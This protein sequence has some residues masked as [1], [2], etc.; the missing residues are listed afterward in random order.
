MRQRLGIAAALLKDPELLIL[1]EPANGLD[2]DGIVALR[3]LLRRLGDEGR[4]VFVSSHQL[5]EV[6]RIADS[7]AVMAHGRCVASGPLDGVLASAGSTGVVVVVDDT[8]AAVG[9]LADAGIEAWVDDEGSVRAALPSRDA[10]LVARTLAAVGV[11][12]RELRPGGATLEEAYL[13]L[14]RRGTAEP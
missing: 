3:Q 8:S 6:E 4:T 7:V 13:T 10:P 9:A 1:D 12:P 5:A 14:T 11:Y 2:P